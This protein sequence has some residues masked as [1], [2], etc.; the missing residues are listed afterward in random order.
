M[1]SARTF[2]PYK[3]ELIVLLWLAYFFNQAD[4]QVYSVVL[5]ALQEDMQL[6]DV[7]AGWVASIFMWTYAVLVPVA[8]YAGDA[9]RRKWIVFG[10]LLVWST[11]TMLSGMCSGLLGLV[12]FRSLATGGGE[13]FYYPS[14]NSLI[15][16]YHEKTRALA[17]SI[18]QTSVY[19]GVVACGFVAGYLADNYGWRTAFF[20]FGAFGIFLSSLILLRVHDVGHQTAA[21]Q[22]ESEPR[23]PFW[24]VLRTVG[25]K[26]T[27]WALCLAFAGYNFAGWG[28]VNWLPTFLGE[29]YELTMTGAGGSAVLYSNV[30]ALAGVLLAGQLSDAWVLRRRR[31]RMEFEIAGLVLGAPFLALMGLT[32]Q[33]WLC[34]V[35]LAG[36][37]FCRGIYDSNLFA[38]LFDVIEPRYRGSA[39]G[40]MLAMAFVGAGFAPVALGWAKSTIGLTYGIALLSLA[41]LASATILWVALVRWF[42]RDENRAFVESLPHRL[43]GPKKS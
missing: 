25:R 39:V 28:A 15:G 12:L 36:F 37:G 6:G 11:A 40:A 2:L 23:L 17:M 27:V 41:F 16:Q 19:A 33:Y 1:A 13:A 35:G 34:C 32:D 5:P 20:V 7:E 22:T 9:F 42:D 10:S 14:A 29:K 24:L 30:F 4:R 43:T 8:G 31:I 38:V 26:P 3:W 21:A 18:H